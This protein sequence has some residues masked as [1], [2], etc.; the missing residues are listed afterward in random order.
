LQHKKVK[1][2]CN[3]QNQTKVQDQD[4]LIH[5]IALCLVP[6]I[7]SITARKL[8]QNYN[9]PQKIFSL[10]PQLKLPFVKQEDKCA[11]MLNDYVN[12]A[13]QE[14]KF[15]QKANIEAIMYNEN[16]YPYRLKACED[17][18]IVLFKRGNM[19]VNCKRIVAVVGTRKATDYGIRQCELIANELKKFNCTL[20]SGLAYGI[21]SAAHKAAYSANIQ[22]I[23]VLAHG[24]DRIYPNENKE[25]S[26]K[27]ELNG[28]LIT[29]FISL[30]NPDRENFPKRNRIVA[31]MVD[32]VIV[33]EAGESG[34][35]LI[36]A[37]IANSYNREVFAIPGRTSDIFSKGC[38]NLIKQNKAAILT[39]IADIAW[40]LGWSEKTERGGKAQQ[41]QLN[42]SFSAQEEA[43]LNIVRQQTEQLDEISIKSGYSI[44]QT[45]SILLDLEFKGV[46]KT[47]PG[48]RYRLST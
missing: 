3:V 10:L 27:M 43:I 14:L 7:G 22:N 8:I 1:V 41:T 28:G 20:I 12:R 21:D 46:L 25:L 39:D 23:G 42:F 11:R 31:G 16:D 5:T 19:D 13:K 30:T 37:D 4:E 45:S 33:V 35:A 47:L 2:N 48:K 24:L 9:S 29:E 6:G 18:P 44:G 32:A 38:N 34:G 36:T 40:Y 17:S 26:K 15:M